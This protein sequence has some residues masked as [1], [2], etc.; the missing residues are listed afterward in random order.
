MVIFLISGMAGCL[1]SIQMYEISWLC[2][3]TSVRVSKQCVRVCSVRVCA[4]VSV[5]MCV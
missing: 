5:H 1:T 3:C 2:V 4:C